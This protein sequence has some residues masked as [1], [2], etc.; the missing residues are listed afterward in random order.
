MPDRSQEEAVHN[1]LDELTS[2]VSIHLF[3]LFIFDTQ[4]SRFCFMYDS[5]F[6]VIAS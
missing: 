6:S 3:W 5:F 4:R 1:F 2:E